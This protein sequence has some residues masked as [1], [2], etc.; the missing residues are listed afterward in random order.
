MHSIYGKS[1]FKPLKQYLEIYRPLFY[2]RSFKN[3]VI[4]ICAMLAIQEV[5]SIKFI[6]EKFIKKYFEGCLNSFYYFLA[7]EGLDLSKMASC[8]VQKALSIIQPAM[9]NKATIYLIID[10]TLQPK[11][12]E[13]FDCYGTLFDH[14]KHEGSHFIKGHCFV[15]LAMSIPIITNHHIKYITLPISC[16]LYD[17]SK[18]KLEMAAGMIEE[19]MPELKDYQ[20]IVLCDAWYTKKPF[21]SRILAFD[22]V[23]MIGAA[24]VDTAIYDLAPKP[25]GKRGR[26][27][28]K[29]P[30]I[31][32]RTLDYTN[33]DDFKMANLKCLTNLVEKAVYA[34]FTTTNTDTFSSVRLYISTIPLEMIKSFSIKETDGMDI[35]NKPLLA[36][37][38]NV[39]RMRWP[40]EVIFYQQKTFWSF[41]KYM[42]RS[43]V[44]I[45]KY[46]N[47]VGV[48]YTLTQLLPFLHNDFLEYQF[49]SPQ[50]T[51]Y[52]LGEKLVHE[53]IMDNL[54]KTLQLDGNTEAISAL[55]KYLGSEDIAS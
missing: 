9:K 49:Q 40:I 17:K 18:T 7:D 50:E 35:N 16:R 51:K 43:K 44:A 11:F 4:L 47:L 53:L 30:R 1:I 12:G 19:I 13:H 6:Y 45:E 39:Y 32:Y 54:L 29:G 42:V 8:T 2:K 3:F 46:A 14:A 41:E 25:T 21:L 15:S 52:A 26:P 28:K 23:D 36:S 48:T 38:F 10:D 33:H 27:A 34:T 22:N 20:V 24:R 55:R 31:N 5:R 37:V